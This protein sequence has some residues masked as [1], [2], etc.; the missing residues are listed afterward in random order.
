MSIPRSLLIALVILATEIAVPGLLRLQFSDDYG[1][2]LASDAAAYE[3]LQQTVGVGEPA[4]ECVLLDSCGGHVGL[5]RSAATICQC[6]CV[7]AVNDT[8]H[9][10]SAF[11]RARR[12]GTEVVLAVE[13]SVG[14]V[15]R[16]IVITT[17][18]LVGGFG[19]LVLSGLPGTRLFGLL[20][21]VAL[22]LAL[23]AD[24][25]ILPALLLTMFERRK[26]AR[27]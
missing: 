20:A 13:Q 6:G 18:L 27:P 19:T 10:L 21:C 2:F 24:L 4:A 11:L 7:I 12:E 14:Q 26:P 25:F 5:V 8:I 15:G 1:S 16:A 9:V 23:V 22:V 3:H 17:V